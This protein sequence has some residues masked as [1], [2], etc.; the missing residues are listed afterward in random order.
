[1]ERMAEQVA[2]VCAALGEFPSIRVRDGWED[3]MELAQLVLKR[4]TAYREN[5][6]EMGQGPEKALSTLLILDRGFDC[7]SP[8][9]HEFT[10]Q[11]MAYD[12]LPIANDVYK[13]SN[14]GK[15]R[16]VLLDE[17]DDLW[18]KLR[19]SHIAEVSKL[20][21]DDFKKFQSANKGSTVEGA[22]MRDLSQMIKKMPQHQKELSKYSKHMHLAEDCMKNYK[23]AALNLNLINKF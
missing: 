18:C 6:P 9:L 22:S 16:E 8:L 15:E 20:I 10:Y 14:Q 23:V 4:L 2:T 3:N 7:V 5:N 19:H 12:L 17:N 1:M 13:Y 21:T 11:A